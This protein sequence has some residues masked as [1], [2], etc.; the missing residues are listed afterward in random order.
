MTVKKRLAKAAFVGI[1][2]ALGIT[3]A[4]FLTGEEFSLFR[5]GLSAIGAFIVHFI[6]SSIFDKKN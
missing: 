4:M 5:C 2:V 6:F 3:F 1:S